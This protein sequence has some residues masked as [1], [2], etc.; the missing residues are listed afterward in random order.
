VKQEF[1]TATE[2]KNLTGKEVAKKKE[3]EG[4]ISICETF[5]C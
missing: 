2:S 3:R 5:F 1:K 4:N